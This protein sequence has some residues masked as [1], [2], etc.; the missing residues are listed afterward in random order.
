MVQRAL[1]ERFAQQT[2]SA[3]SELRKRYEFFAL[4]PLLEFRSV[5]LRVSERDD[6]SPLSMAVGSAAS[7]LG[8]RFP[9]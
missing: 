3:L 7:L 1:S 6:T 9:N 2:T 4:E 5:P 8:L